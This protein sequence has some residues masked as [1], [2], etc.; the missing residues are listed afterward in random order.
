MSLKSS[1]FIFTSQDNKTVLVGKE[2]P[3]EGDEQRYCVS[4]RDV[5]G[6]G[7]GAP[8][9]AKPRSFISSG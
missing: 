3:Q 7:A 4:V 5:Q 9:P 6:L 2:E 8:S 1:F